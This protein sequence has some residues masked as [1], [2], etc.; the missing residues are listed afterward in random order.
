VLGQ[1]AADG[2]VHAVGLSTTLSP[3]TLATVAGRLRP[4]PGT[5]HAAGIVGGLP[6]G[7][8]F[9]YTPVEAGVVVEVRADSAREWGRF[10]HRLSV[11][12]RESPGLAEG[13]DRNLVR[14]TIRGV[15]LGVV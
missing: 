13:A 15:A 6:G 9:E 14:F 1:A 5:R 2:T 4:L 3:K 12:S 11:D 8:D 7:A 10:R